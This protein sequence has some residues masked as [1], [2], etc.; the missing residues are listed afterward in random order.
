[1]KMPVCLLA[2][3]LGTVATA[4]AADDDGPLKAEELARHLHVYSWVTKIDLGGQR[5]KIEVVHVKDGKVQGTLLFNDAVPTNRAFERIVILA[6]QTPNG[7]KVS[8]QPGASAK[9]VMGRNQ[10][11]ET[12]PLTAVR[13]IAEQV[14]VG[15]Y[16]LGG[17][18]SKDMDR[19]SGPLD[20]AEVKDGL[21]LRLHPWQE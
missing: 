11:S 20:I 9:V 6:D 17:D 19:P 13:G 1:M 3:V 12:V 7:T 15:D 2:L 8:I 18:G 4:R 10:P 14:T 21:V 5:L 16:F